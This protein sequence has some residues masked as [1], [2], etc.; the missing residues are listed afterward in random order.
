[1]IIATGDIVFDSR[2]GH[3]DPPSRA[4]VE[5]VFVADG[6]IRLEAEAAAGRD[7]KFVGEGTFVGWSGI[8]LERDYDNGGGRRAYNNL[9]PTGL[10]LPSGFP[11]ECTRDVSGRDIPGR[12]SILTT[13]RLPWRDQHFQVMLPATCQIG[14]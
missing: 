7:G 2:L 13:H 6:S 4:V 3:A 14:I 5:G 12:K 10:P 11:A 9:Y 8:D 1:M